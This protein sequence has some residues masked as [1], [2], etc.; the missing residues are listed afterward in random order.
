M[1]SSRANRGQRTA[2]TSSSCERETLSPPNC[3]SPHPTSPRSRHGP[4]FCFD[5]LSTWDPPTGG[6]TA[7][8]LCLAC[9]LSAVSSRSVHVAAGARTP[10][11]RK[12][13]SCSIWRK[14]HSS[15]SVHSHG[16]WAAP[17][18][19]GEEPGRGLGWAS[20][21]PRSYFQLCGWM[22]TGGIAGLDSSPVANALRK[23]HSGFHG[24]APRAFPPAVPQVPIP[25]SSPVIF[26]RFCWSRWDGREVVS[27][28]LRCALP[29]DQGR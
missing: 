14:D 7:V 26:R 17:P 23:L 19:D 24:A 18:D 4:P 1:R 12:D 25:A 11:L 28:W 22:P 10:F 3:N 15:L 27:P 21:T 9:P 6:H 5:S 8:R 2:G 13:E 20:V 29:D 16:H